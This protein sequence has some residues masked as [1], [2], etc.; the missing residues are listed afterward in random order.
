MPTHKP[1]TYTRITHT[2]PPL[3]WTRLYHR[4]HPYLQCPMCSAGE[5]WD[6]SAFLWR[7]H[8]S[9][10]THET[11]T[12]RQHQAKQGTSPHNMSP[13]TG[14][15]A[16]RDKK[17]MGNTGDA[18]CG[19]GRDMPPDFVAKMTSWPR[20]RNRNHGTAT[21]VTSKPASGSRMRTRMEPA[22]HRG[23]QTRLSCCST[24]HQVTNMR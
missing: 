16:S 12:A 9:G 14:G 19:S 20:F 24:R 23:G 8:P 4:R 13:I 15:G 10:G 6:L 5:S 21:S 2:P 11:L 3:R 17:G 18:D 1:P 7:N 22:S